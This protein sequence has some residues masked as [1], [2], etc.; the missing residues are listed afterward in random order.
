MI[1]R[2]PLLSPTA[3][4][5]AVLALLLSGCATTQEL[6]PIGSFSSA[7]ASL[8][9]EARDGLDR[10]NRS[11]I[12]RNLARVAAGEQPLSDAAMVGV[13][14]ETRGFAAA[15]D[16][17]DALVGYATSL[18]GLATADYAGDVDKASADLYGALTAVGRDAAALTPAAAK[19]TPEELGVLATA[20]KAIGTAVAREKQMAAVTRAVVTADPAV[21]SVCQAMASLFVRLRTTYVKNLDVAYTAK[22]N[23]YRDE[24][25]TLAFPD[26]LRRLQDLERTK[27]SIGNADEFLATLAESATALATAHAELRTALTTSSVTPARIAA[28]VGQLQAFAADLKR[29]NASLSPTAP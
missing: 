8:S 12:D 15:H 24:A 25:P 7:A 10:V 16:A 18:N 27:R 13:L 17:L 29:F 5:L 19:I 26:R 9:Q 28:A 20:V 2:S 3:V 14:E 23:A 1:R 11:F 21:Q 22:F 4:R 6:S